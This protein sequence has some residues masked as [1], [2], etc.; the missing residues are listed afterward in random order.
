ME[1][2]I[3]ENDF[4]LVAVTEVLPKNQSNDFLVN[5]FNLKGY[6]CVTVAK[7]RGVCLF[8][9]E[10]YELILMEKYCSIYSL[11]IACKI[12]LPNKECFICVVTY[13]SPSSTQDENDKLNRCVSAVAEDFVRDTV[14]FLGDFNYPEIEWDQETVIK[15]KEHPAHKFLDTVHQNYLFQAVK[16]PTH[17]R[18]QQKANIL[19]L[20]LSNQNDL[21]TDVKYMAPLGKSHHSVLCFNL[22]F[23]KKWK[24]ITGASKFLVNK[25]DFDSMRKYVESVNWSSILKDECSV[26]E[27]WENVSQVIIKSCEK[28]I[29]KNKVNHKNT[30]RKDPLPA[31]VLDKI[32][33]KRLAFKTHK[34]Y[35]TIKN[36]DYY[37]K[38]RN[39]VRQATRKF[40]KERESLL[41]KEAKSNP[42]AFFRYVTDKTKSKEQ[43]AKLIQQD[44]TFT[45]TDLEKAKVLNQF[46]SSVFTKDTTDDLPY[47]KTHSNA[48]I[49]QVNIGQ[50]DMLKALKSMKINKSPGPDEIHPRVLKELAN[51]L[52]LPLTFLFNKSVFEGKLPT[53]WKV[54][55]VRPIFKKGD[56]SNPGNYRP[57][58]LTS[59]VCK[60]F[61]SFIRDALCNHLIENDILSKDQFGFTR[62]RSCVT[63]LLV[64][65]NDWIRSLERGNSVDA[66]YL[67]L[68]KAFDTVSHSKLICK[69]AGYGVKGKLLEWI[70][71]FLCERT[72]YVNV[73]G[74]SSGKVNVT[75]GVP[76]GSVLGPTLFLYFINDL[77][78]SVD[79]D[80]KIFADDTK[81][82][83]DV[84]DDDESRNKVQ[85]C[86]D[87]LV[88]WADKWLMKFN[89]QKCKV[90]HLGKNNPNHVYYMKEGENSRVLESTV[91]EKDLGVFVD[92]NLT[93]EPHI[94][95]TVLKANRMS[96]L[97]VHTITNKSKLIM[98]PLF[99]ALVRPILEYGNAVW[100][101]HLRKHIDLLEGVQRRFT[102]KIV[103][104]NDKM[105]YEER[106]EYL[107]LPSLEYRRFRGD[108]IEVY[109]VLHKIYDYSTTNNL[110]APHGNDITRGHEF[111][112]YKRDFKTT[113]AQQFFTNRIINAWNNLPDEA[114]NAKSLNAFKNILDKI[115]SNKMYMIKPF[116]NM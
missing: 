102:K 40:V 50:E 72:Q 109:K 75:S 52:A 67:D 2:L 84:R 58:S 78:D 43:I 32:R 57:V 34:K 60:L 111:K 77:P 30:R 87:Q 81:A 79:C 22:K 37:A 93:F 35:P 33:K 48:G 45:E 5:S 4:D 46:F 91:V 71:D 49:D 96:G 36:W 47:F 110:L 29:P 103:G 10:G 31:S 92:A 63:Q 9:K 16:E 80:M 3:E 101:P 20:I 98:I 19:A 56:K 105:T 89:S 14:L 88:S 108:M 55:E 83:N 106:L 11:C 24:C 1:L 18:M 23:P 26:D 66:I 112:L 8:V 65:L 61:E 28:F 62:G 97:L 27:C 38:A 12:I 70:K 41:A 99:K 86:I 69:L 39:Q 104:I 51:Q 76:Q 95:N 15:G 85:T 68:Q 53:S 64:T 114:V 59:V 94:N 113:L 25:G 42:K 100:S 21:V 73:N 107:R 82:Y 115:L 54:A 90:M 17:H 13:R 74:F 6:T 116:E 44:G 7:G